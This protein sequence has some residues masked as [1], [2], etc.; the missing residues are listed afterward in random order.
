MG[1]AGRLE[2]TSRINGYCVALVADINALAHVHKWDGNT[3][4]LR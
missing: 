1:S 4:R 2:W 3:D